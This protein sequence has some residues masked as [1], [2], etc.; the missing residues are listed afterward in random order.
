MEAVSERLAALQLVDDVIELFA[1]RE[2]DEAIDH[3]GVRFFD[4]D[5]VGEVHAAVC[6]MRAE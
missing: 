6:V 2:V 1:L 3:V 4:V 5:Q